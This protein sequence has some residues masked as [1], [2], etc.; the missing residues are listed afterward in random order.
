MKLS[1]ILTITIIL[2]A[3]VTSLFAFSWTLED[4]HQGNIQSYFGQRRGN[5]I[6]TSFVFSDPSEITAI[7]DGKL[8]VYTTDTDDE[9]FLFPSTLGTSVMIEHSE[10]LVSVYGNLDY[11]SLNKNLD[12]K[13]DFVEKEKIGTSGNSGYQTKRSTLEFQIFDSKKSN[14]INPKIFMPRTQN[15]IPYIISGIVLKNKAGELF[16][17][18]S[19]QS[20]KSGTYKIY[21]KRNPIA[22]PYRSTTSINGVEIDRLS[23]DKIDEENNRIYISGKKKYLSSD[24]YPDENLFLLG[25]VILSQGKTNIG[26]R[27]E[28]YLGNIR[29]LNYIISVV[30]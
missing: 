10:D 13:K 28:D 2:I 8:L 16:E 29:S 24:I 17:I 5:Y 12:T 14:A 6:S 15:E 26:I 21:Q 22:T 11:A 23:Y 20:F 3:A 7:G 19:Q 4:V 25:E 27:V 1:K 18:N 30:N 9:N